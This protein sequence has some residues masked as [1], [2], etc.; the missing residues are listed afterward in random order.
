MDKFLIVGLEGNFIIMESLK[1]TKKNQLVFNTTENTYV[2]ITEYNN[3]EK[4]ASTYP[5][6]ILAVVV[7]PYQAIP[8]DETQ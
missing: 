1:S 2:R 6:Q 8:P 7:K 3:Y 4:E 5:S